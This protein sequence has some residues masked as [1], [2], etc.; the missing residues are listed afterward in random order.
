MYGLNS[1]ANVFFYHSAFHSYFWFLLSRVSLTK[2]KKF[3]GRKWSTHGTPK[4][5]G[6]VAEGR[7]AWKR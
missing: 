4:I 2:V 6:A 1:L 5:I 7:K 3:V